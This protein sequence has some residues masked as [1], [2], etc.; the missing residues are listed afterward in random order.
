MNED[1]HASL[2][3]LIGELVYKNQLLREVMAS[4][5]KAIEQITNH[6]MIEATS[7][8]SCG[9]ANQ[10]IFV[11]SALKQQDLDSARHKKYRLNEFCDI[12]KHPSDNPSSF[13]LRPASRA[14]EKLRL[15]PMV[16]AVSEKDE[17]S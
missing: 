1:A 2:S 16:S 8:C 6:L 7:P 3:V 4:K 12:V 14:A 9:A 15:T 11:R 5:D 10:L 13:P 17:G